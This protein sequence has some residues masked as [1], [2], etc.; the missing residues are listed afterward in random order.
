MFDEAGAL[1]P[2][3]PAQWSEQMISPSVRTPVG[4]GES[5][6]D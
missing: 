2:E 3:G 6:S 4:D 1:E 5:G